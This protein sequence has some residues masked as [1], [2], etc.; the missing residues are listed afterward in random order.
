MNYVTID[1]ETAYLGKG[2]ACALAISTSNG[3]TIIDEWYHFIK[4]YSMR[5]DLNNVRINGI[6][7]DMVESEPTFPYYFVD[8]YKRL[9]GQIVF[10][11]NARFDMSVLADALAL[12]DLPEI[13]FFYGDTVAIAR[14]LWK[15]LSNHKLN[16]V[17]AYL[18]FD[19]THHQAMEDAYVCEWI[20][21]Q[22]LK[23]TGTIT[24]EDMMNEL[25]LPLKAFS[26][27]KFSL[28]KN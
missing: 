12:Y 8:I 2:S 21:R 27:K 25:N 13:P 3:E 18:H 5:F 7:P 20:V 11:H 10:A 23:E 9:E 28:S 14:K 1:F 17:A 15:N 19:F 24:V 16:T 22:A 4:P 26:I 6:Y